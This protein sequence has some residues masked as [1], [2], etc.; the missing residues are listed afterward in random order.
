MALPLVALVCIVRSDKG[1]GDDSVAGERA[2]SLEVLVA[3][4]AAFAIGCSLV[5]YL[6]GRE[7]DVLASG[8]NYMVLFEVLAVAL[9]LCCCALLLSLIHI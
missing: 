4:A 1:D 5:V 3:V 6:S 7:S 2:Q 9:I 8:L